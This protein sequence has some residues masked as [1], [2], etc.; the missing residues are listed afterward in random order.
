M[1]R[2][3]SRQ[4]HCSSWNAPTDLADDLIT[5]RAQSFC[6]LFNGQLL[7]TLAAD[8]YDLVSDVNL[9]TGILGAKIDHVSS[10]V[11]AAETETAESL[12]DYS[13]MRASELG[14]VQARFQ[15]DQTGVHHSHPFT[16]RGAFGKLWKELASITLEDMGLD[17]LME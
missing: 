15:M 5:N 11:L 14:E 7:V 1:L 17:P 6:P 2:L 4:P 9:V 16:S 8:E 10:E 13:G 12:E 3:L